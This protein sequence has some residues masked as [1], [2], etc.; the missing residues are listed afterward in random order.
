[1]NVDQEKTETTDTSTAEL[2]QAAI[3]AGL[4]EAGSPNNPESAEVPAGEG[5]GKTDSPPPAAA[6]KDEPKSVLE[7]VLQAEADRKA[8]EAKP[9]EPEKA[10][11]PEGSDTDPDKV[12]KDGKKDILTREEWA[13]LPPRAKKR[14]GVLAAEVKE[15]R[16]LLS[17]LEPKAKTVDDIT[18]YILSSG[19]T[20][21]EFTDGLELMRLRKLDPAKCY[22][23]LKPI[24]DELAAHVGDALP[25]D[26][27]T[28]VEDGRISPEA[29]KQLVFERNERKLLQSQIESDR[30]RRETEDI[31]FR[32]QQDNA[33][34]HRAIAE[35]EVQWNKT[36]PDYRIKQPEIMERVVFLLNKDGVPQS[37]EAMVELVRGAKKTI[38]DRIAVRQPKRAINPV[39][40]HGSPN[41]VTRQPQTALEA[42][43]LGLAKSRQQA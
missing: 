20:Q 9:V 30:S 24:M 17:E 31:N 18:T 22:A 25:A 16:G 23:A 26:L 38:D 37:R 5:E 6:A 12:E 27:Q 36:D 43:Q 10:A 8:K 3:D 32:V 34:T 2:D 41:V 13:N 15:V 4:V 28:E 11:D 21:A 14:M 29:A 42:A 19:M 7:A 1:M 40:L 39:N 33:T 35:L